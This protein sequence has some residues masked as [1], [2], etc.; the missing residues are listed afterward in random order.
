[1]LEWFLFVTAFLCLMAIMFFGQIVTSSRQRARKY[2]VKQQQQQLRPG[3]RL[4]Y[5]RPRPRHRR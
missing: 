4:V 1:M 5:S 2:M 3:L